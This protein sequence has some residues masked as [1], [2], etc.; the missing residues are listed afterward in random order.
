MTT[1]SEIRKIIEEKS[2]EIWNLK[3]AKLNQCR[4]TK[5]F[6]PI[7]CQKLHKM[8]NKLSR[9]DLSILIQ[10]ITGQNSLNDCSDRPDQNNPD[11]DGATVYDILF[12]SAIFAILDRRNKLTHV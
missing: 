7:P 5:N 12:P 8:T 4:Q 11:L 3:W 6:Y 9:S 10:I 2:Y 1:K